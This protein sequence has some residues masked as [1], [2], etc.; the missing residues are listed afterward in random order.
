V[1]KTHTSISTRIKSC[2]AAAADLAHPLK[3]FNVES[4]NEAPC[5]QGRGRGLAGQVIRQVFFK[6]PIL[7]SPHT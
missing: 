4:R 7:L 5:A 2:A 1:A 6:S 3:E